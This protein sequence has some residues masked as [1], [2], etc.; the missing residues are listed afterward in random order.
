MK[1]KKKGLGIFSMNHEEKKKAFQLF[2]S[3]VHGGKE[4]LTCSFALPL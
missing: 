1:E 3:C 2:V 4:T